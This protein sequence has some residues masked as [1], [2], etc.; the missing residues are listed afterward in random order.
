MGGGFF[1]G[2]G[3]GGEKGLFSKNCGPNGQ[4]DLYSPIFAAIEMEC[5]WART[6]HLRRAARDKTGK[7]YKGQT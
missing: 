4:L 1:S 7:R 6:N 3:G 2:G 5:P